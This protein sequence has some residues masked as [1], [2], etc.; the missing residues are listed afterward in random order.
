M[1]MRQG[2]FHLSIQQ[3]LPVLICILLICV[4]A[5]FSWM[6]YIGVRKAALTTGRE[7]LS[8]LTMQLASMFQQSTRTL[9]TTTSTAANQ[10]VFKNYLQS[11]DTASRKA[12]L[13]ALT[14]QRQDTNFLSVELLNADK[15]GLLC[16]AHEGVQVTVIPRLELSIAERAPDFSTVGKIYTEG[17][18]MYYPIVAA[19]I[20]DRKPIGYLVKWR[21]VHATPKTLEQLSQL[22]GTNATL[23]FGN[24][25]GK[26]WTD[27]IKP[28]AAPPVDTKQLLTTTEYMRNGQAVVGAMRPVP[29]TQWLILIEFSRQTMLDTANRY[30][31]WLLAIGAV[32]VIAGMLAAWL[33][34]RN[35]TGPL[36]KLTAAASAIA[37]GDYTPMVQTNRRDELGKLARSFNSMTQQIRNAQH[38][39]E[40]KVRLRTAQLETANKELEAFSYSVSHDLRAPL[41]IISGYSTLL[42]EDYGATLDADGKRMLSA[43]ISNTAMMGQLIDDLISFSRMERKELI[44]LAVDM[45]SLAE[46]CVKEL[47]QNGQETKYRVQVGNLPPCRGDS[48]MLKQVWLNLV[49][50]AIK[51]SSRQANPCIEIGAEERG[52]MQVYFVRDNGVGFDMQYAHKLFGVFQRLHR[53]DEFEGTGVGL[54]LV[55]RIIDKHNGEVWGEA[56]P[57]KGA[58]FYFSL[59]GTNRQA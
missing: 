5:G 17:D 26:L 50:N 2:S 47:L 28:V 45:R 39:L 7:R 48:S 19:V 57:G 49:S 36:N 1:L 22:I 13:E 21:Q 14:K 42:N 38:E 46:S 43:V 35:I 56:V 55:K 8:S 53:Q 9:V 15:T 18:S 20:Q 58:T 3:R 4:I 40:E 16:S 27:M 12:A 37:A 24:N 10:D 44:A 41:R 33:M 54:A 51:Y 11:G 6:S 29:N 25:D 31:Y 59:P 34:S 30:L 23:Y 52:G 32:L